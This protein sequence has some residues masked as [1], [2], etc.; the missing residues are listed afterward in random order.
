MRTNTPSTVT[1]LLLVTTMATPAFACQCFFN[2]GSPNNAHPNNT[3]TQQCCNSIT[4]GSFDEANQDCRSDSISKHLRE[5]QTCCY[6]SRVGPYDSESLSD[7]KY[8]GCSNCR[9]P[10]GCRC[11]KWILRNSETDCG[12]DLSLA[13]QWAGW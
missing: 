4:G 1:L 11:G 12:A 7:P 3:I 2:W 10:K 9:C 13:S 8:A 6:L 5:F